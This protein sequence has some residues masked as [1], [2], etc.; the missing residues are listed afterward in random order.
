LT[1]SHVSLEIVEDQKEIVEG[2]VLINNVNEVREAGYGISLTNF[3]GS[4]S[5]LQSLMW[6]QP[7]SIKLDGALCR[8]LQ[9]NSV[10]QMLISGII[11]MSEHLNAAVVATVVED[12]HDRDILAKLGCNF[13]Q[14]NVM[15]P[16][17]DIDSL[18][19]WLNSA[20]TAVFRAA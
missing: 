18:A 4:N 9:N 17:S 2:D 15:Y 13:I 16:P 14:G 5:S 12:E 1:P 7:H 11:T 8:N 20:N 19:S 3:G 10:K 6:I